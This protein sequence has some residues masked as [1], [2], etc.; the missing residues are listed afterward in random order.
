VLRSQIER[1]ETRLRDDSV[2]PK[3]ERTQLKSQIAQLSDDLT[4]W[5]RRATALHKQV[6]SV[7]GSGA[8]RRGGSWIVNKPISTDDAGR[9]R[10]S[11][12]GEAV[13]PRGGA[14]SSS[15]GAGGARMFGQVVDLSS[16]TDADLERLVVR[17]GQCRA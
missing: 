12:I 16:M 3:S 13:S 6:E 1:H 2:L 14:S 10:S 9:K 15:G 4:L 11:S 5:T 7:R 8:G 17:E